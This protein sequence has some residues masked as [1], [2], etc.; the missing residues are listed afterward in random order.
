VK[1]L[2]EQ[3]ARRCGRGSKGWDAKSLIGLAVMRS[4]MGEI[5]EAGLVLQRPAPKIAH[6]AW[7]AQV[8]S[9]G[10]WLVSKGGAGG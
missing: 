4:R 9:V 6:P 8:E 5:E 2:D 1:I 7:A 10:R 3:A